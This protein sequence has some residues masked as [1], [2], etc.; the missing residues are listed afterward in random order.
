[1][2]QNLPSPATNLQEVES[3]SG[4]P[5]SDAREI[6]NS[7]RSKG[8]FKIQLEELQS[9]R[10]NLTVWMLGSNDIQ[11]EYREVSA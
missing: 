1:M 7:Y 2:N 10:S 9:F 11:G 6:A 3:L 5:A 4:I 8:G